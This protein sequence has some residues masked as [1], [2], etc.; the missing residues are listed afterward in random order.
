[1]M[2]ESPPPP[3]NCRRMRPL[4]FVRQAAVAA[5]AIA[6]AVHVAPTIAAI[7]KG[8]GESGALL[9]VGI[10]PNDAANSHATRG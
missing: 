9:A 5:A 8:S 2:G 4:E 1:M 10:M 3:R 6:A 7:D